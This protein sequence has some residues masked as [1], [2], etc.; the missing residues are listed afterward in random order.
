[1]YE[2]ITDA[3]RSGAHNEALAI[4]QDR[5]RERPDDPQ[6]WRWL[7]A[8]QAATGDRDGALGSIGRALALAPDDADLQFQNA[9][10]LLGSGQGHAASDALARS[11]ALDPNQFG[12]YVMQ[13]QLA[14]GRGDVD[15]AERLQRLA[16]RIEPGHPW[17]GAIEGMV[18]LRRGDV[19]GAQAILAEAAQR[20][21]DDPQV[22]Y[23]LGFAYMAGGN[24]AFA[25]QAFR[26]VVDKVPGA[27]ALRGLIAELLRLQGRNDEAVAELEPLLADPARATPA[28]R[29]FAG[30][31]RLTGGR[32]EDALPLLRA[33]LAEQPRDRRTYNALIECW[34]RNG[35]AEDARRT[36]E[37]AIAAAPDN[38][39][40]WRAR[41]AFEPMAA[42]SALQVV[43]RWLDALPGALPGLEARMAILGALGRTDEASEVASA[44]LQ[45]QPGHGQ[46][47]LRLIDGLLR[48][49]PAAAAAHIE[50]LLL[51]AAPEHRPL[52]EAWRALALDRLGDHA[53]AAEAW[54]Y[55]QANEAPRRLPLPELTAAENALPPSADT[56]GERTSLLV[57]FPGSSVEA[58]GTLLAGMVPTFRADRFSHRPPQDL[59]QRY[60]TA[61]QLRS[62]ALSAAAV[63]D[64]WQQT[65]PARGIEDEIV[66]WLLWWDN[67]L[68]LALRERVPH[69]L[70]VFAL[71]DPRDMLLDW[72][73]FGV[74][75]PLRMTDPLAAAQWL[76]RGLEHVA[77]LHEQDLQPHA[78]LRMD[79]A[80][81]DPAA[82]AAQ[83]GAAFG[84]AL[85]IPDALPSP[86]RF[87]AGHWRAYREVLAA[88]FALLTPVAV[89][90]GYAAD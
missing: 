26:G 87:P 74:M 18:A 36:L 46:A 80:L 11:V 54:Q 5:A 25:E 14:L 8:A 42:D 2:P 47:E 63:G 67:A 81:A 3:V 60:D 12:A 68:L 27:L 40:A 31:L 24:H 6:A 83:A 7:A 85:P 22:R 72:L 50:A 32:H 88:S 23:A 39:D 69:A 56:G 59:L 52:L 62:G 15:E 90:L 28:L 45:R 43:D 61:T 41:L 21:P 78:L 76:A 10:L 48:R 30:E 4:A 9:G 38:A 34:R 1:M 33:A 82:L 20:A 71:R 70:V 66:D 89:R 86:P 35:D 79:E 13:A 57:G 65:L 29:R 64:S 37:A 75:P 58:V 84:V 19:P 51:R 73:A 44:I 55:L 17:L 53:A 77:V 49:D 16:A